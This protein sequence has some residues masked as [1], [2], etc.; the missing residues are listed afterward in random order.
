V[1]ASGGTP[2]LILENILTATIHPDGTTIAFVRDGKLWVGSLKGDSP[3]EVGAAP[4]INSQ[5]VTARVSPDGSNLLAGVE[6][7]T[8]ILPYPS[9]A[10]KKLRIAGDPFIGATWYPD[11]RRLLYSEL[12]SATT[13]SILWRLDTRDGSRHALYRSPSPV[14][15]PVVSPDSKRMAYQT[16]QVE[17]NVLEIS[18]PG[19]AVRT[20]M[21]GSGVVSWLPDWGPSGTRYLVNTDRSGTIAIEEMSVGDGF[22]RRLVTSEKDEMLLSARLAPDGSR[23]AFLSAT[24]GGAL[25]LMLAN[26]SG[27]NATQISASR[28]PIGGLIGTPSWSPDSKWI[29]YGRITA[30]IKAQIVKQ[31]PGSSDEPI[32]LMEGGPSDEPDWINYPFVVW[33]PADDW[34][35]FPHREGMFLIS[36]DGKTT[37]KLTERKLQAYGFSRD[38]R[39]LFGIHRDTT[40]KG[41]QWQLYSVDV[42]TGMDTLLG[43]VDLPASTDSIA[44][45]SVHPDGTRFLTSIAK[46]PFD[47]WMMEGFDQPRSWLDRVLGR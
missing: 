23:M 6:R 47:I 21:S 4:F 27:G 43:P 25:R 1:P 33:S 19:G 14:V 16:G 12:L 30:S 24:L 28:S 9:G 46:W 18:L 8:W 10:P 11:S 41:A 40:G 20:A 17:W 34:I 22:S 36:P 31:R 37:R 29:A 42:K 35:V 7:D 45:F 3:R 44:G 32:V 13:D 5:V 2:E 39:T 38:G 15:G 26:A